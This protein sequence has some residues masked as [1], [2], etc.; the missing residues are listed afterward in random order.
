MA[1]LVTS[2]KIFVA[3]ETKM[4]LTWRVNDSQLK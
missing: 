1:Y 2:S 4:V 3:M